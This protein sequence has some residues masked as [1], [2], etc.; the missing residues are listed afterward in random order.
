MSIK[1]PHVIQDKTFVSKKIF[2]NSADHPILVSG[3]I[4]SGETFPFVA[5]TVLA[6]ETST[7]KIVRYVDGESD[8]H[9]T[10][11][12]ILGYQVDAQ[13]VGATPLDVIID[14]CIH[15]VVY[16]ANLTGLDANAKTDLAGA[17]IFR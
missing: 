16:E 12:G 2:L 14:Y 9:G 5:G 10:A 7:G 11:I 13:S 6:K 3:Q 8:G 1:V 15:G 17:I 4:A